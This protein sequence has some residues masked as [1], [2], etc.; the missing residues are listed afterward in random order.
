MYAESY[1]NRGLSYLYLGQ[2][3]RALEDFNK[4]IELDQTVAIMYHNRGTLYL[5]TGN[6]RLAIA[7]F[8]RACDLGNGNAC[9]VLKAIQ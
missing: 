9:A 4:A 2:D 1:N 6:K 5:R 8:Q 3:D 7:D